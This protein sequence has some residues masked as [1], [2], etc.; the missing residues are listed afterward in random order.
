MTN[1]EPSTLNPN[2]HT[3]LGRTDVGKVMLE[4]DLLLK[5]TAA[6]LL[7]PDHPMVWLVRHWLVRHWLVRHWL[8]R[9]WLVRY[10][11]V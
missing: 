10:W 6:R 7:H 8:V 5:Q 9:H 3:S 4:A 11:L 2:T 1:P